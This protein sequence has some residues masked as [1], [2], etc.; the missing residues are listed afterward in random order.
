MLWPLP[1]PRPSRLID[2][3]VAGPVTT[4]WK[5]SN[6]FFAA[7][8]TAVALLPWGGCACG[9]T[10]TA[11]GAVQTWAASEALPARKATAAAAIWESFIGTSPWLAASRNG[12]CS[13]F[14]L[15]NEVDVPPLPS[16]VS[17]SRGSSECL[18]GER[19]QAFPLGLRPRTRG[20]ARATCGGSL[21]RAC[22]T[23]DST[24]YR[25]RGGRQPDARAARQAPCRPAPPP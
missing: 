14:G 9:R 4:T 20:P 13:P 5:D 12:E 17:G 3:P 7:A 10:F 21:P 19:G 11:A 23:G 16:L 1:S 6:S 15:A 24:F 18:S 25:L 2:T 22:F 8:M